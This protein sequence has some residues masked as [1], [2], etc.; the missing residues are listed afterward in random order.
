MMEQDTDQPHRPSSFED[1]EVPEPT[2]SQVRPPLLTT[3]AIVLMVAG[4]MNALYFALFRPEGSTAVIVVLV[5]VAQVMGA[6]LVFLRHQ[7]GYL[8]GLGMGAIGVVLGLA[9]IPADAA[10]GLIT[11]ALS[12]YVIWA[13]ASNR[14]AFGPR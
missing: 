9:R 5:A 12:V 10:S 8:A 7:A 2:P 1:I 3:A 11:V 4:I 13:V 14:Q 6:T